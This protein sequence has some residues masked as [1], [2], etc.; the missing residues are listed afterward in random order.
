[1]YCA[2][3]LAQGS[4][5]GASSVK[6]FTPLDNVIFEDN[7]S[8]DSL[9]HFPH[10]WKSRKCIKEGCTKTHAIV[11][12]EGADK[13]LGTNYFT[14]VKPTLTGA[15]T[16]S[17]TV[18]FDFMSKAPQIWLKIA[19]GLDKKALDGHINREFV[20][21]NEDGHF[22]V[23]NITHTGR[24]EVIFGY[25]SE[26]A[27]Y[28]RVEVPPVVFSASKWYHLGFSDN[29]RH[30]SC[31]L[32]STRIF[33]IPDCGY[34]P[35]GLFIGLS[36]SAICRHVV[37][38]NSKLPDFNKLLV[39]KKFVTHS[40]L[41]ETNKVV[42]GEDSDPFLAQLAKWLL[43]NPGISIEI[44]GYTDSV[45][46]A[47]SNLSLSV[48]RAKEVKKQLVAKG[49]PAAGLTTKG[50]GATIPLKSNK[51]EEGRAENRRVEFVLLES[52]SRPLLKER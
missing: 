8:R 21:S 44:D 13:V 23:E 2:N 43:K 7:F 5:Y 14:Y 3:C 41:F 16:D 47:A 32:D 25:S 28:D 17:F 15:L 11:L 52:R 19:F 27:I 38:A 9:R 48:S 10:K 6:G 1:M 26:E 49:V 18:E 30:I 31:Y 39:E 20:F 50:L 34:L 4:S 51:T 46:S 45:G 29:Q 37:V 42:I 40:I 24:Y 35:F 12:Q 36:D 33:E 22:S